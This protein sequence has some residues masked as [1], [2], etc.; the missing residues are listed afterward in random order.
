MRVT[1]ISDASHCHQHHVAGYGFWCVSKRGSHAGQGAFKSLL[2]DALAAETLA[3]VNA[4]HCSISMGVTAAGDDV[5][6]QTDCLNAI[7]QLEGRFRRKRKDLAEGIER[8]NLLRDGNNLHIEFRHVRGH[9]RT[10]DQR[11]KAQRLSDQ[12]ARQAM[13]KARS[14]VKTEATT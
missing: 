8:F 14:Q 6:I 10:M 2:K 3:I 5:L 7:D 1:I 13:K 9:T 11:S 4:L 12:R